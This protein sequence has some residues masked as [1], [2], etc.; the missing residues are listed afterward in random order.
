[1]HSVFMRD[2]ARLVEIVPSAASAGNRHYQNMAAWSGR[3]YFPCYPRRSSFDGDTTS[4]SSSSSG[5][6]G[7]PGDDTD[8][9]GGEAVNVPDV[10]LMVRKAI[11]TLDLALY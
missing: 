1:M 4:S 5:G 10:V 3:R 6:G 9:Q 8:N 2:R 11:A 7:G